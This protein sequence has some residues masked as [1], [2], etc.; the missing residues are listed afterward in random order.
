MKEIQQRI[1]LQ[2]VV[3]Y[4]CFYI[5]LATCAWLVLKRFGIT[6]VIEFI[7]SQVA[8]LIQYVRNLLLGE[9]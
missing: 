1:T 3:F 4:I 7:I 2:D 9:L 8:Y 6:L 5:Y